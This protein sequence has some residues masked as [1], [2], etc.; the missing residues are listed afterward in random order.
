MKMTLLKLK[1]SQFKKT[2][3]QF[4]ST[5]EGSFQKSDNLRPKPYSQMFL[6]PIKKFVYLTFY[7]EI[8]GVLYTNIDQKLRNRFLT[9]P[10]THKI[11]YH[12]F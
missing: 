8:K 4:M 6:L 7:I 2:E 9:C 5:I 11:H 12:E 10:A 1:S 3:L